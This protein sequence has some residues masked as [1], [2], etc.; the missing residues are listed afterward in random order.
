MSH[1]EWPAEDP[2]SAEPAPAAPAYPGG[3]A[4]PAQP[5][6]LDVT[7]ADTSHGAPSSPAPAYPA[8]TS[9]T[10]PAAP[11]Y[12]AQPVAFGHPGQPAAPAYGSQPAMPG[13]GTAPRT[14]EFPAPVSGYPNPAGGV[15][16]SGVPASPAAAYPMAG[17]PAPAPYPRAEPGRKG[18]AGLIVVSILAALFLVSAAGTG[19]LYLSKSKDYNTQAT[20]LRDKENT[21][22]NQAGQITTLTDNLANANQKATTD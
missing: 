9:S 16:A 8:P 20:Q 18:R 15:P 3:P 4:A 1:P 22:S 10:P 6:P 19:Y 13:Y 14:A 7:A 2:W 17:Y 21:I 12:P 11:A 5:S